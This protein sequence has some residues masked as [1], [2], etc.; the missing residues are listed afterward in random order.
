MTTIFPLFI[1]KIVSLAR[2]NSI[3]VYEFDK[4]G[5]ESR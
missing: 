3:H 4:Q 1:T 5:A 2:C